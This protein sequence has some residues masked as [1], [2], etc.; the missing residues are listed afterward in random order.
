MAEIM[1]EYSLEDVLTWTKK[2]EKTLSFGIVD[3]ENEVKECVSVYC[4]DN[5][6]C[7]SAVDIDKTLQGA[8][9][10]VALEFREGEPR[11]HFDTVEEKEDDCK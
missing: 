8:R 1:V 11:S 9:V 3:V 7:T 4:E 2:D 6:I 5:G 10:V